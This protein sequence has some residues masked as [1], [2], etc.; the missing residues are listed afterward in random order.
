[1]DNLKKNILRLKLISLFN[2]L[3]FYAP[4]ALL[5]RTSRGITVLQFFLLQIILYFT[6]CIMEIPCGFIT[7]RIGYK[8]SIVVSALLLLIA[9][10]QFLY[11]NNFFIFAV[12]A[13]L[14][15]ISICFMSGTMNA[16][17]YQLLGEENFERNISKIDNYGTVGFISS[18]LLFYV[19][20]KIS[21]M[22]LLIILTV[23]TTGCAFFLTLN[24]EN[25]DSSSI[26]ESSTFDYK[27]LKRSS[28]WKIA[29]YSSIFS[30]GMIIINFFYV[31]KLNSLEIGELNM[32]W[33]ILLY[34]SVQLITPKVLGR[35]NKNR[36]E[37]NIK[38]FIASAGVCFLIL[39]YT[40]SII[41]TLLFMS[42]TSTVIM[43]PYYIFYGIQNHYID[44]LNLHS[45]RATVLSIFNMGNNLISIGSFII[46]GINTNITGLNI[47]FIVGV[48]YLIIAVLYKNVQLE[49]NN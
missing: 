37:D 3:V 7:D 32:T 34:S 41:I 40:N 13:I 36:S 5:L 43:V 9:R 24:L 44:T 29:L 39:F 11:A 27:L 20:Y 21:G 4:I 46:L 22:G 47:F 38:W 15:G 8:K 6:T 16:Y 49:S 23:L 19:I 31:V 35:L 30:L 10:A 12:E 2:G 33:I 28:F 14:E 48:M 17:A 18:T 26:N 45:N 1:M 25:L 42:L